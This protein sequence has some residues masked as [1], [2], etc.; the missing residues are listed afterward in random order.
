MK[1]KIKNVIGAF[2]YNSY[3]R[4]KSNKGNRILLYHSIGTEIKNDKYG[5]SI[6]KDL[7]KEHINYLN[8]NYELL[9]LSRQ[10]SN[11]L[12]KETI[13]ISFD[14]GFYDNIKAAELL[15]KTGSPYIIYIT[16]NFIGRKLY[17]SKKE[18]KEISNFP[19]CTIGFHGHT[20]KPLNKLNLIEQRCEITEGK[21]ILEDI[22]QKKIYHASYPHGAYNELTFNLIKELKFYSASCSRIGLNNVNN[23]NMYCLRRNEIIKS[24]NINELN[25]KIVG[26]YD[27]MG[28]RKYSYI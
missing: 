9:P 13:S 5:F 20:H 23:L 14:D 11:N 24:D 27:F 12:D 4:F 25:K 18:V 22:I 21:K 7:F 28:V 1:K 3:R 19:N 6:S 15:E 26:Y 10:Y 2:Y 16:T 17:L 8:Y